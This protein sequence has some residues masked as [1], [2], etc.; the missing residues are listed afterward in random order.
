M[1]KP[2]SHL[3][4]SAEDLSPQIGRHRESIPGP[5]DPRTEALPT[6]LARPLRYRYPLLALRLVTSG[7]LT[8]QLILHG[9]V[10]IIPASFEDIEAVLIS[11]VV[12]GL[13]GPPPVA[14]GWHWSAGAVC[15]EERAVGDVIS[16]P[17]P[18][19]G[20]PSQVQSAL[21]LS[22]GAGYDQVRTEGATALLGDGVVYDVV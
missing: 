7:Q 6:E 18:D 14:G 15:A 5:S 2:T 22:L 16:D 13:S 4:I 12:V 3:V 20:G 1:R 19:G 11:E 9:A 10:D 21:I 17:H 8:Q